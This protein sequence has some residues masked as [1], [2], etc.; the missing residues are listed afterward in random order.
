MAREILEDS[1]N[2]PTQRVLVTGATGFLGRHLCVSLK[3][4]GFVVL[5]TARKRDLELVHVDEWVECDLLEPV[6]LEQFL[7]SKPIAYCFH[8]AALSDG[9]DVANRAS[10]ILR[11]NT[12]ATLNLL[13]ILEAQ[14]SKPSVLLLSSALA[15]SGC[16]KK[17][18]ADRRKSSWYAYSK[19][20]S[21][22]VFAAYNNNASLSSVAVRVPN[23]YGP[24]DQSTSRIIPSL[25]RSL[26]EQSRFNLRSSSDTQIELVYVGDV[27]AGLCKIQREH[28]AIAGHYGA[29]ARIYGRQGLSLEQIVR[30]AQSLFHSDSND[31][32][33]AGNVSLDKRSSEGEL[34]ALHGSTPLDEGFRATLNWYR[35]QKDSLAQ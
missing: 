20:V 7:S 25:F 5:A 17:L 24:G 14:T 9:Q 30:K 27:V 3:K 31:A 2:N 16:P 21:E 15:E 8:L 34:Y 22:L 11:Q 13:S 10:S 35:N 33:L 4:L 26:L 6:A 29:M 18:K 19:R 28:A 32:Q 23:V 12:L 1:L